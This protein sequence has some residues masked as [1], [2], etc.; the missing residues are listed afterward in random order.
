MMRV[1]SSRFE[2]G[3]EQA[4]GRC[5]VHEWHSL[6]TGEVYERE[7]GPVRVPDVDLRAVADGFARQMEVD[8]AARDA[9]GEG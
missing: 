2:V 7:Y 3:H 9:G 4:D 6:D 5:Y 8:A 1:L